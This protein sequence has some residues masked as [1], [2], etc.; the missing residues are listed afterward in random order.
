MANLLL[1]S[2]KISDIDIRRQV[3]EILK[4]IT[5]DNIKSESD[6]FILTSPNGTKYKLV[7]DDAGT[8]STQSL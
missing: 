5:H 3:L 4:N 8:L 6:F 1:P 2:G 7:V